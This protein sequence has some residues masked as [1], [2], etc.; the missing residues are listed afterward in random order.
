MICC[1]IGRYGTDEGFSDYDT[2]GDG[3][4]DPEEWRQ[5]QDMKEFRVMDTDKDQK[6]SRAEWIARSWH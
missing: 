2:N 3:V 6:V 1:A 4:I 5:G